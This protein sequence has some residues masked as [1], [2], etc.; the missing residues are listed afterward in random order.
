MST[1]VLHGASAV[2]VELEGLQ[3]SGPALFLAHRARL[4]FS[5]SRPCPT[6]TLSE[7]S[8]GVVWG[9]APRP[10]LASFPSLGLPVADPSFSLA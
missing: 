1:L 7:I 3:A 8:L 2:A 9:P 10:R 5:A 6:T 4:S